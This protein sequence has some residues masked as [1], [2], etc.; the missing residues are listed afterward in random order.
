M[1]NFRSEY[2]FNPGTLTNASNERMCSGIVKYNKN[3]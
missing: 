1:G 2:H 3:E